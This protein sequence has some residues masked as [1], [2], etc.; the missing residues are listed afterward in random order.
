MSNATLINDTVSRLVSQSDAVARLA[1]DDGGFA[2]AVA[3]FESKDA[4]A[5]SW[6]LE[7]LQMVPYCE[8]ICEWVRVKLCALRC[9]EICRPVGKVEVPSLRQFAGAIERLSANEKALR[10]VADAVACGDAAQ[11]EAVLTELKIPEL[12]QLICH[13]V[14]TAGYQ[15]VCHLICR[16]ERVVVA[17]PLLNLRV[18]AEVIGEVAKDEKVLDAIGKAVLAA[19]YKAA[20]SVIAALGLGERCHIFCSFVCVWWRVWVC[21]ELCEIPPRIYTG[22]F[23]IEEARNF[24][25]AA[26]ELAAYPGALTGL[27]DAA[28]TRDAGSYGQIVSRFGLGAYCWQLCSW[29]MSGVCHGFCRRICLLP[30]DVTPLFTKVGC[31]QV[32]PPV[33]DFNPNGT[34]TVGDLAFTGT[35]PLIGLIPD[36]T[37]PQALKYRFTYQQ[38]SP[39]PGPVTNITGAMVPPTI[40][41][42]VEYRF[43]NGL[44]WELGST[45]YYVNNPGATLTIPQPVGPPLSVSVNSNTDA[46]GWITLPLLN[47]NAATR[48]GLFTPAGGEALIRLDTTKLTN[49]TF[50]LTAPALVAGDTV[51]AAKLSQ[52]PVFRIGF[53][54]QVASTSAPVSSNQLNA[55]A[56]SNT[57]YTYLRHPD[58]P[59]PSPAVTTPWVLSV[60]IAELKTSGACS[61]LDGII[62]PL[63]TAYHPYLASCNVYLQG[64]DVS[65]MTVP[66]GGSLDVAIVAGNTN[67]ASGSAGTPFDLTKLPPC[68]YILW[69]S[70]TFNL[71]NGFTC[72]PVYGTADDYLGFCTT[73]KTIAPDA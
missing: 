65:G 53:E 72:G 11:Y 69:L 64:P 8:I 58:W 47:S 61:E 48:E 40:I 27:V 37:A 20:Q 60:D 33:S 38:T 62:H 42:T 21:R 30:G 18:A 3:A 10:R 13:W 54:A 70:A 22:P 24:A 55:I 50:D 51:P 19:D 28:L 16:P 15:E 4:A 5:F 26:R 43:W 2:A 68:A 1:Q 44:S 49:E 59:G 9:A 31:Y 7:R 32:G 73:K 71:T 35:I 6:V 41:G 12:C 57:S 56:L 67:L 66:P 46:D 34:T 39:A 45:P 63:Y 23:A 17:D 25:L 14:C 36:G 29:V 52:K